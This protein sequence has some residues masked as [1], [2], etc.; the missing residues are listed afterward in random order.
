[1]RRTVSFVLAVGL[2]LASPVV[3]LGQSAGDRRPVLLDPDHPFWSERAPDTLRVRFETTTG[4]F[5]IQAHRAWA[6][7][8][9]DRLYNLVRSGFYDDSRFYRVTRG[10]A[11]F[12]IA[13]DPTAS[14]V[15]RDRRMPDDSVAASNLRG[16]VAYAMTGPQARTTQLYIL[17]EDRAYQDAQGFAP[18]GRVIDGMDVVDSLY[19]GY[20]ETSGGG[21]RAGRQAP[22]FEGGNAYLDRN[23][24]LL[25]R[26][27]RAT[28]ER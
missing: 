15:W 6:P 17:K 5:V 9:V 24:P 11:Q 18:F 3:A 7:R 19:A 8:G 13:G 1:M 22:L 10:F 2:T 28:I 26:L 14:A 25:D 23:Y 12:G 21:M 4:S 16:Y 20:G 27:L